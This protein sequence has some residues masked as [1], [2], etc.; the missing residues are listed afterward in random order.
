MTPEAERILAEALKLSV[1]DRVELGAALEASLGI[2]DD[3]EYVAAWEAEIEK[4]V[5]EVDEGGMVFIPWEEALKRI[6]GRDE[7]PK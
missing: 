7:D 6:R 4:R 2:S 1:S 5:R 3:P